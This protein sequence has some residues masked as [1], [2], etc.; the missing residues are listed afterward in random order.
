[1]IID[2]KGTNYEIPAD[3]QHLV[4]RKFEGMLKHLGPAADAARAYVDLGKE[5]EAHQNG[6]IWHA[7]V[8]LTVNGAQYYAKETRESILEA[9]DAV[10]AELGRALQTAQEK[11]KTIERKEGAMAKELLREE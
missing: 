2:F 8:N 5:T 1:M 6:P 4:E 10:A 11:A 7:D 3:L 9:V